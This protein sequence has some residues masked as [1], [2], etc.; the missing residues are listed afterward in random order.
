MHVAGRDMLCNRG[1]LRHNTHSADQS[2][3]RALAR[4]W[5]TLIAR[6]TYRLI[7]TV[8]VRT[9]CDNKLAMPKRTY[10]YTTA[11]SNLHGRLR[12]AL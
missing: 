7:R 12:G 4:I 10:A 6:Q 8:A 2:P 11:I 9:A 5:Q 1:A 3:R